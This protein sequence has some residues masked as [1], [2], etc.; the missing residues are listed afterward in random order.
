QAGQQVLLRVKPKAGGKTRDVVVS[1]LSTEDAADLRY[2]EWEY[3]RRLAVEEQAKGELGYV[4]LRAMGGDNFTEW[5]RGFYPVFTR[6]GLIIDVRNNQGGNIDSW[7][8]GR[9]LRKAWFYWSPRVGKPP[10]WNMQY[11]F[12]G[13]VVVLCN[14]WTASD[15]EAFTEG[16]KRLN[17]GK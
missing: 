16:V 7:I 1:P 11:A 10:S 8:I 9:L 6:K 2:H 17:I 4:H 15:G 5:A 13:H 14:E 3:T 12:R